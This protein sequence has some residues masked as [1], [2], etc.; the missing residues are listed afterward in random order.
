MRWRVQIEWKKEWG[1]LDGHWPN[2]PTADGAEPVQCSSSINLLSPACTLSLLV[3]AASLLNSCCRPSSSSS[4]LL[5][6]DCTHR[7]GFILIPY[8]ELP[9]T[10][11]CLAS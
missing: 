3:P 8:P 1:K 2:E 4:S 5:S 6:F 7:F 10:S 9:S 11:N